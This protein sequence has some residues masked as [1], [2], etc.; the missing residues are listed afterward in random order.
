MLEQKEIE[1][2]DEVNNK[3][4]TISNKE[5]VVFHPLNPEYPIVVKDVLKK[6]GMP[7]SKMEKITIVFKKDGETMFL[8]K[9]DSKYPNKLVQKE[10]AIENPIFHECKTIGLTMVLDYKPSI[11]LVDGNNV[12]YFA[13]NG[14]KELLELVDSILLFIKKHNLK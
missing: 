5:E 12:Y 2:I 11:C 3:V 1:V 9:K 14:K 8:Y 13:Y 7:D 10:G 6:Y 4:F